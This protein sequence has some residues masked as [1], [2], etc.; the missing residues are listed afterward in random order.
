MPCAMIAGRCCGSLT[1]GPWSITRPWCAPT[2][3]TGSLIWCSTSIP[4][5]PTAFTMAVNVAHSGPSHAGGRRAWKERSRPAGPKAST[6]SSRSITMPHRRGPRRR[7]PS[8][9]R[10]EPRHWILT[11]LLRR[12]WEEDRGGKGARGLRRR[13]GGATVIAAYR[14]RVR[15]GTPVSFPVGWDQLDAIAPGDFTLHTPDCNTS[16]RC[17]NPWADQMPEPSAAPPG[18]DRGGPRH[19]GRP[20]ASH[21]R[22]QAPGPGPPCLTRA[23]RPAPAAP[24]ASA[25][26]PH[27]PH[28]A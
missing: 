17:R 19:P 9:P 6:C 12:S 27:R 16:K 7:R 14:P 25:E 2:T 15:P 10:P 8:H 1:S 13:V 11:S 20:G 5:Q 28:S 22:G 4:R 21:A 26:P 3:L 24:D 18:A 23:P